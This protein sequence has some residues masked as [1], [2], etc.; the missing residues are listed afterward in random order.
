M[1]LDS[2]LATLDPGRE[3]LVY[4]HRGSRSAAAVT[5]LRAAGFTRVAHLEGGIDRWST[6]VDDSIARY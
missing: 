2:Q 6:E 5:R 4:C 3:I 1:E